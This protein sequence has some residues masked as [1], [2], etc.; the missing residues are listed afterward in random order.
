M[1]NGESTLKFSQ[2]KE[3]LKSSVETSYLIEGED[4]FFRARAVALIKAAANIEFPDLNDTAFEGVDV[5]VNALSAAL[6]SLPF[7]SEKRITLVREWYPSAKEA[8][9]VKAYLEDPNSANVFIVVNAKKSELS[10]LALTNVDCNKEELPIL[11]RWVIATAAS[12]GVQIGQTEARYLCEI[13][14]SDMQRISVETEKLCAYV[15]RGTVLKEAIDELVTKDTEAVVFDLTSA[16]VARKHEQAL[17]LCEA[18]LVRGENPNLLLISMYHQFRRMLFSALSNAPSAEL[19]KVFRVKEFA[20][21]KARE[22]AARYTKRQLKA[23]VDL[24]AALEKKVKTFVIAPETAV[25][26]AVVGLLNL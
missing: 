23:G 5:E 10:K 8:A 24:I 15:A 12:K 20:V 21:K 16:I 9:E 22:S 18:L 2:L 17:S 11:T 1:K 7:M 4:A 26:D 6:N 3:S 25:R 13:C 14:A 19:A